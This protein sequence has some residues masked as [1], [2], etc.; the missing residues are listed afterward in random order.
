VSM[1]TVTSG[2]RRRHTRCAAYALV[3]VLL[4]PVLPQLLAPAHGRDHGCQ[5]GCG[6]GAAKQCGC[7]P[8]RPAAGT[9]CI[10]DPGCG[11]SAPADVRIQ[12]EF[13]AALLP[14]APRL[15]R[16]GLDEPHPPAGDAP[17][18]AAPRALPDPV[19][20]LTS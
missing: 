17:R 2:A 3:V 8:A 4:A 14:A 19:P 11:G 10:S 9:V 20:R 15:F 7:C 6:S 1:R 13:R 18:F 16:E 12:H 5:C